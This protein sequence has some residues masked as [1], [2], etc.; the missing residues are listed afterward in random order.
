[1]FAN[2]TNRRARGQA[3]TTRPTA[4]GSQMAELVASVDDTLERFADL[5]RIRRRTASPGAGSRAPTMEPQEQR[6]SAGEMH[7]SGSL[8]SGDL[9]ARSSAVVTADWIEYL[10]DEL[11]VA[12]R[13]ELTRHFARDTDALL[14]ARL[15]EPSPHR[16][17][18]DKEAADSQLHESTRTQGASSEEAQ[19]DVFAMDSSV[20]KV[21]PSLEGPP[22]CVKFDTDQT[23][24]S[25][26]QVV[27]KRGGGRLAQSYREEE[28]QWNE[29]VREAVQQDA[30]KGNHQKKRM[31]L[32]KRTTA[33]RPWLCARSPSSW[34]R[35]MVTH[36]IFELVVMIMILTDTGMA[37]IFS[38]IE[39]QTLAE[40]ALEDP[41]FRGHQVRV[42]IG[43]N[44]MS[45]FFLGEIIFRLYA[46][47]AE[48]FFGE[49][50]RTNLFD[51]LMFVVALP[52]LISATLGWTI[53][54]RTMR[55]CRIFRLTIIIRALKLF[56]SLRLMVASIY[57]TVGLVA[58]AL[59]FTLAVIYIF[60]LL[61]MAV[62]RAYL[63]DNVEFQ[64][65]SS[66]AEG[67]PLGRRA[68]GPPQ[69]D[70][71]LEQ[72]FRLYGGLDTCMLTLYYV[73]TGGLEWS[74]AV[75]PLEM[76]SKWLTYIFGL[77]MF[78]T[79]YGI[80]SILVGIFCE[81]AQNISNLDRGLLVEHTVNEQDELLKNMTH[82]FREM[83]DDRSGEIDW[84]QF[85]SF[86][87]RD[88]IQAYFRAKG[89]NPLDAR[90]LFQLLDDIDGN[91]NGRMDLTSFLLGVLRLTGPARS[92]DLVTLL[93][94]TRKNHEALYVMMQEVHQILGVVREAT[95]M[96]RTVG[97]PG[98][99]SD[100]TTL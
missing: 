93:H 53:I 63:D 14:A 21:Q 92:T 62:I 31:T 59:L 13:T 25:L 81:R 34:S 9:P 74:V 75:R 24:S 40:N 80:L 17:G 51:L 77:Y 66:S 97:L 7:A 100:N 30:V 26:R 6:L 2:D 90:A 32:L 67:A 47:R 33:G 88:E 96:N 73:I 3:P 5:G 84:Q 57:N 39:I 70:E 72:L 43:V 11:V 89:M 54:L 71:S 87:Q 95:P 10:K 15:Q 36:P 12:V 20:F 18:S 91:C 86:L 46:W 50:W 55:V 23:D 42:Y 82:L 64:N 85:S 56:S 4:E 49:F 58:W 69:V 79:L 52:S 78:G 27:Q 41:T 22:P 44:L 68:P 48:F 99:D 19:L 76:I 16:R 83:D 38:H 1:M 29:K 98:T 35:R 61:F 60:S 45:L 94:E 28:E 8:S 37:G 65:W